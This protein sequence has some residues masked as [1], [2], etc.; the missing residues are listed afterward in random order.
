M[1]KVTVSESGTY[2]VGLNVAGISP[3]NHIALWID[4]VMVGTVTVP[5]T[6]AWETYEDRSLGAFQLSAGAHT[7]EIGQRDGNA[8]FVNLRYAWFRHSGAPAAAPDERDI[9]LAPS[10]TMQLPA[11]SPIRVDWLQDPPHFG[12]WHS[13][14]SISWPVRLAHPGRYAVTADYSTVSTQT[15]LRVLVDRQPVLS[16]VLPA[17]GAWDTFQVSR[18][19]EVELPTGLHDVAAVWSTPAGDD[20]GNLRELNLHRVDS[21]K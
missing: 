2:E 4:G 16:T 20:A 11:S 8:G 7:L 5:G 6:G 18:L 14:D 19:G 1:W 15:T 17:T 13:G 21:E 12:Y 3:S 9:R 10:F